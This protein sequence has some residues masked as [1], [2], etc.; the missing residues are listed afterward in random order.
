MEDQKALTA[1]FEKT[2]QHY[3]EN[4]GTVRTDMQRRLTPELEIR[5][6][7]NHRQALPITSVDYQQIVRYLSWNGWQTKNLQGDQ[8]LR[9]IPNTIIHNEQENDHARVKMRSSNIRAEIYGVDLIQKYCQHND[10]EKLKSSSRYNDDLKFTKKTMVGEGANK[11]PRLSFMDHNF[12]VSYMEEE[13]YRITSTFLPIKK[14]MA[15]WKTS[16]KTFRSINR[17]RF[18][19]PDYP[20]FVDLSIVKTNRK[21]V[22]RK[23]NQKYAIP[24]ET[25]QEAEVFKMSASYE[26]ELEMDNT[27]CTYYSSAQRFPEYMSKVRHCIRV[28]LSALQGTPYPISYS[29]QEKVIHAYMCRMYSNAWMEKKLPRPFFLGPNSIP[30]QLENII[31]GMSVPN[32]QTNYSITEKADGERAL[33]Y[34]A[35]DGRVYM[36]S[37]SMRVMFTGSSTKNKKCFDSVIDGEFIMYG[38]HG[39]M[40]FLFAAFD[41]YFFGGLEK[42]ANV[43]HLPFSTNNDT[44]LDDKY[45]LSLL[46]TFHQMLEL[47]P[48][49]PNAS[50]VFHMRV[51]HFESCM[52]D[53]T[54]SIFESAA[55]VW[56][57]REH[58]DYEIDGL[59]LTPTTFG[60][61][62]NRIGET[63]EI[64]GR[65]FTWRHSFKWK[66]PHYNTIDFLVTTTKD[67]D[68]KDLVR[69]IIQT[70]DNTT[71]KAI[72]QYKTLTLLC[73]FDSRKQPFMNPFDDV[74]HDKIPKYYASEKESQQQQQQYEAK[75]FIPTVPYH[76]ES[77]VCHVPL[78]SSNSVLQM[79][80]LEGDYFEDDMI[81]EFQYAKNDTTKEG[82]WKWVPLRVRQD[83]T[84]QLREGKKSMNSYE[85]ANSNWKSIHFPV[86]EEIITGR[87]KVPVGEVTDTI[88]YSLLERNSPHTKALRDFHNLY[89]KS[90]LIEGVANHLRT[91][92]N[93]SSPMLIDYAVGKAGDLS[94]WS[95]SKLS[96]VLGIDNHGDNITN[97][98]DGACVRYLKTRMNQKDSSSLK[99][100]F[101]E[102][103]SALNIRTEGTACKTTLEKELVQSVFGQGKNTNHKK[104]AFSHGIAQE[105]F[106][107][108]SCQFA[109][110]YFFENKKTLHAFLRNLSECTRLNGYFIGTCFDGAT[111]FKMLYK[112]ENGAVI[113]ENE[114]IRI[115]KGGKKV[116]EIVKK[117][118]SS[119]FEADENCIGMPI[120][121][122]Q[123]SID[124]MFIE[125]LV[126]FEYLRR[127]M[128]DYGFVLL[129]RDE[130][131]S[132]GFSDSTGL[133]NRLFAMMSKDIHDHPELFVR[134]AKHMSSDEKYISFMNRYFIFK[135][136]RDLSQ[137]ALKNMQHDE[138]NKRSTQD[139]DDDDVIKQPKIRK[140][141][142]E[143]LILDDEN[144]SPIMDEEL[145]FKDAASKQFYAGLKEKTK[146]KLA[147]F[148]AKD[149][150]EMID[151]FMEKEKQKKK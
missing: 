151:E 100:L 116:F 13:E 56:E 16:L 85:T 102:G 40:L 27:F 29:E 35:N 33:L 138:D 80:T 119:T 140:I 50:C 21:H 114:S 105:G 124:K 112:R 26:V 55:L 127:L 46:K 97:P 63:N 66:P 72:I 9:I 68:G 95:R 94:K 78:V 44:E 12:N 17:V 74:L 25:I 31:T 86:T 60:V 5:F 51:K 132:I 42:N 62:G 36:I 47:Q 134:N 128:E 111:I 6:G 141:K 71:M 10:L 103:T 135:K 28:I 81:V 106:H 24:T 1:A 143:K 39:K 79:K 15:D 104:Y 150:L 126:H 83:K 48:V 82:P 137:A 99:V 30:L 53:T 52:D 92:Q 23:T 38:K 125:Y 54:Q 88:Y 120:Y 121:V 65:K 59:I 136:V 144:Y 34:V 89:V 32:I 109:L 117:Y 58:F 107:I 146:Q 69:N 91:R 43:R 123:E 64:D 101:V 8:I 61:G 118:S 148:P 139:D 20:V 130:L 149:Q 110:H 87:R 122:Y 77:Y 57:K 147:M 18:S 7:T 45:R 108:S 67:K 145:K 19:H 75:P 22:N 129:E 96:F 115:D 98:D 14:L 133:F 131:R 142:R 84:Q 49:T 76:P 73:G 4:G 113:N 2:V 93:I 70:N 11:F 41:I 90:K 37:N 3:L